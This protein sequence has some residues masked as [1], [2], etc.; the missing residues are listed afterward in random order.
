[1]LKKFFRKKTKP[2]RVNPGEI[3]IC[4]FNPDNSPFGEYSY[5]LKDPVQ[6]LVLDV[7]NGWVR[8]Q[9]ISP[10][11]GKPISEK[12][13]DLR[14][15]IGEFLFCKKLYKPAKE[16]FFR[17][18]S[19]H[20]LSGGWEWE[21]FIFIDN[22]FFARSIMRSSLQ[23]E[24]QDDAIEDMKRTLIDLGLENVKYI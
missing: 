13:S 8:Y 7:K 21:L 3:W 22:S 15:K 19:I 1:M 18:L 12:D 23:F 6:Y 10:R 2:F 4:S 14:S 9:I 11:T 20:K 16:I 17:T 5:K 24:S